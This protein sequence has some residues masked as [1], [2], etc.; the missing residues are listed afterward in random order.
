MDYYNKEMECMSPSEKEVLQGEKLK[1]IVKTVYERVKPYRE[2]MDAIKLKPEDIKS[3]KDIYKLPFTTKQDLRDNYPFGMFAAD[4]SDI[5]RVHASRHHRKLTVV[6]YTQKD[7]D[8][9]R[10][11]APERL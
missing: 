9:W 5:I 10:N 8:I 1:K 2:K 4:K 11:V 3:I 7:I 6:G